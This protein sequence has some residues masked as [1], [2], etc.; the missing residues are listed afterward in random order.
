[1]TLSKR[2]AALSGPP[3][4]LGALC[5]V[6]STAAFR[7]PGNEPAA[8]D[9]GGAGGAGGSTVTSAANMDASSSSGPCVEDIMNDILHCGACGHA[10]SNDHALPGMTFCSEGHCI[11]LCEQGYADL[12]H[13]IP[14][15]PDDGCE[16]S[17]P[18]PPKM[19]F[20][21]KA[22]VFVSMMNGI[23]GADALCD[24]YGQAIGAPPGIFKAWIGDSMNSPSMRLTH[25][26]GPYLRPDGLPVANDWIDLTDGSLLNPPNVTEDLQ[27]LPNG[28]AWTGADQNGNSVGPNCGDWLT[29]G[30]QTGITGHA[31]DTTAGWTIAA[32]PSSCLRDDVHLY[33]IE[34]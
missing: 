15:A 20:I 1:M 28:D 4:L 26:T 7:C 11:P 23:A 2:T 6:L 34:Q 8:G 16:S 31:S 13:P 5:V 10:C 27:V 14:P 19:I 12:K 25:S 33:C 30:T 3:L 29:P 18:P 22:I 21:S 32:T 24:Q 9:D 17:A